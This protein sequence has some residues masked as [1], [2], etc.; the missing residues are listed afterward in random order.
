MKI[1]IPVI[2]IDQGKSTIAKGFHNTEFACIYDSIENSYQWLKKK[3]ICKKDGNLSIQLKLKGIY[4]IISSDIEL[5]A[6]SL[7]NEMGL[8]V[9]KSIGTNLE[10]NIKLFEANQ[11]NLF[12]LKTAMGV[13]NC[14]CS[15]SHNISFN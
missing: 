1:I 14:D 9:Y 2:D 13:I 11:L 15:G 4:T 6:F 5:M 10:E 12:T 3:D 7:F 8:K